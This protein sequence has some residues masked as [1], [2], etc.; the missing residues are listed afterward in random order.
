MSDSH[1]RHDQIPVPDGDV[2]VHAGDFTGMGKEHEVRA[3]SDFVKKLPHKHKIV[4]A[5]NHEIS[6]ERDPMN[7]RGWLGDVCIYLENSGTMVEGLKFWGSPVQPFFDYSGTW[8]FGELEPKISETWAKIPDNTDVLVTHSP[9]WR[10]LDTT[11][12]GLSVGCKS[13]LTA[14]ERIKPMLHIFGHIHEASGIAN[15]D[16]T[17]FVNA[18]VLDINYQVANRCT[19]IELETK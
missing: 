8:V 6:F 7:A 9:P 16:F 2:L 4:V 5:G 11:T 10:I 1:G 17:Q 12:S 13:L 18:S 15:N 19:V 14:V 3:F